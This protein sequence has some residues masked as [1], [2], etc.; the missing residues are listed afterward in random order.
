MKFY[1]QVSDQYF[2]ATSLNKN[3]I[4]KVEKWYNDN[5]I[6]KSGLK[7][8]GTFLFTGS[9]GGGMFGK[10]DIKANELISIIKNEED[11]SLINDPFETYKQFCEGTNKTPIQAS[12]LLKEK[13]N[14]KLE[15]ERENF[16]KTSIEINSETLKHFEIEFVKKEIDFI[17]IKYFDT[18]T[19][20]MMFGQTPPPQLTPIEL[21]PITIYIGWLKERIEELSNENVNTQIAQLNSH[22]IIKW[23]EQNNVLIDMIKQL[24]N[25][26][27]KDN[28]PLI[29]NSC[30]EIAVF[31]KNNFDCF[32]DTKL[33]TITTQLKSNN[34][35]PK[36]NRV[37]DI[38]QSKE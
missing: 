26:Y 9:I 28:E 34:A 18:T 17:N 32:S 12:E 11:F 6:S 14:Q 31:L 36:S 30:E 5:D 10:K 16:T 27:N 24:K 20:K 29:P 33:S 21:I 25:I 38:K 15:R 22:V 37:I 1:I 23:N 8:D 2:V 35:R 3:A 19:P 7:S 4:K 13:F